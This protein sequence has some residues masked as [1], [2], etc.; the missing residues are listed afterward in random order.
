MGNEFIEDFFNALER[1]YKGTS[2]FEQCRE[3]IHTSLDS[4]YPS[5]AVEQA[6]DLAYEEVEQRNSKGMRVFG[7]S[8]IEADLVGR[9]NDI[10]IED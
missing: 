10:S 9:L 4:K 3:N 5:G 7:I 6:I 2:H 1:S 8:E